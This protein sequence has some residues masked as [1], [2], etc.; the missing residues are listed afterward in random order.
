MV[1]HID[2]LQLQRIAVG[3]LQRLHILAGRSRMAHTGMNFPAV[4][5][6]LSYKFET[7]PSRGTRDEQTWH[8]DDHPWTNRSGESTLAAP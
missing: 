1:F 7:E 8:F 2:A 4:G 3:T 6:I 5:Q